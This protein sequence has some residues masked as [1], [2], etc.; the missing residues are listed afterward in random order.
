MKLDLDQM[1]PNL[2]LRFSFL[3]PFTCRRFTESTLMQICIMLFQSCF[4]FTLARFGGILRDLARILAA[5]GV[6]M[7]ASAVS[8]H[9]F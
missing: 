5:G 7:P 6:A 9:S 8:Q 1:E 2:L 3:F 4:H